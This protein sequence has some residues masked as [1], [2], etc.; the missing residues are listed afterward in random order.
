MN[1]T[2]FRRS[3]PT[4]MKPFGS[5]FDRFFDEPFL[6]QGHLPEAFEKTP[7]TPVN[8]SEN[9]KAFTVA[10]EVPGMDEKDIQ[11]QVMGNQLVVSGE[12]RFE[13]EKKEKDW[14]RVECQY[15]SFQRS[16]TLPANLKT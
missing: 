8:I 6:T 12:K 10:L 1:L 15:G 3:F 14:H 7:W 11:V 9:E 2:P 4:L 13:Q 16:I 5:L